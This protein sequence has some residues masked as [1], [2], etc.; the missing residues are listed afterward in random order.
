M[1]AFFA[2]NAPDISVIVIVTEAMAWL[3]D[4]RHRV[5]LRHDSRL[6]PILRAGERLVEKLLDFRTSLAIAQIIS[7]HP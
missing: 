1:R 2:A 7:Q 5:S 3:A 4:R 6:D